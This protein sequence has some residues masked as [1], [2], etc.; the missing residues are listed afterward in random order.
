MRMYV[1][2]YLREGEV[3]TYSYLCSLPLNSVCP[4]KQNLTRWY[5]LLVMAV[6]CPATPPLLL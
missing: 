3:A 5:K 6:L 4:V 1:A 2:E